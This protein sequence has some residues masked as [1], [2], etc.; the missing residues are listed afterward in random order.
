[1]ALTIGSNATAVGPNITASFLASGG[2]G[3]YTYSVRSG[4]AGGTINSSSGIYTAP[5]TVG[6]TPAQY[7]D[8]IQAVDTL[9]NI[10]LA[11]IMVGY[12]INLLCDI[13]Q[14]QMGLA[15]GRVYL[16]DQKLFQP[17]DNGL[18]IAVSIQRCKPIG[19]SNE[20]DSN[21]NSIQWVSMYALVDLDIISRGPAARDQKELVILALNSDYSQYQQAANGF[22]VSPLP[23]GSQFTNLSNIDGSAIPYRFKISVAMQYQYTKT[24]AQPY[25]NSFQSVAVTVNP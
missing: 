5:A 25:Y 8:I 4:G 2:T 3:P 12:P 15:Q 7:I 6:A 1:M 20:H 16:W 17:A 14:N 18:Y 11:Q 24:T 13:I 19:S 9:G 21:G 23:V 10:G 22:Y